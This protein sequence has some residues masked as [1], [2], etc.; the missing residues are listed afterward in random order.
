MIQKMAESN[1]VQFDFQ[2]IFSF[3]LTNLA[4]KSYFKLF[5]I[6]KRKNSLRWPGTIEGQMSLIPP[7]FLK[8]SSLF[9]IPHYY[10]ILI[11][12]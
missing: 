12:H 4:I 7:W 6:L 9:W 5:I 2:N 8:V 3:Y 1:F 10:V 11:Q